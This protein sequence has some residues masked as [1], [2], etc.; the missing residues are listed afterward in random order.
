MKGNMQAEAL[1]GSRKMQLIQ[2][3]WVMPLKVLREKGELLTFRY[4][5]GAWGQNCP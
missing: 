1:E 5:A 4:A 3:D 2:V